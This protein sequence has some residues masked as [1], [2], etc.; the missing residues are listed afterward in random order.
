M[1]W[2][3][4]MPRI[5]TGFLLQSRAR[6]GDVTRMQTAPSEIRQQSSMCSGSTISRD[7]W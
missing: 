1:V 6:S 2:P 4:P 3:W 5:D 7:F